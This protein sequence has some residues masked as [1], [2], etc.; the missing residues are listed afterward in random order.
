MEEEE[1][2]LE[3]T[4]QDECKVKVSFNKKVSLKQQKVLFFLGN[5][6]KS[7]LTTSEVE[8]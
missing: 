8:P 6:I 3:T 5:H 7:I 2:E 4:L 1:E